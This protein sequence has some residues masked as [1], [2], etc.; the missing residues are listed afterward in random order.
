MGGNCKT[1]Q[2]LAAKT[3]DYC[4]TGKEIIC[5]ATTNGWA[6]RTEL[7]EL[8]L[9]SEAANPKKSAIKFPSFHGI[10]GGGGWRELGREIHTLARNQNTGQR[11]KLKLLK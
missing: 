9:H 2:S 7:P 6:S 4:H 3:K 8:S 10:D 1:G 5:P 11:S